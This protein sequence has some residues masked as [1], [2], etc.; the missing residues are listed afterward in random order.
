MNKVCEKK[1]NDNDFIVLC[2]EYKRDGNASYISK[3]EG[4]PLQTLYYYIRKLGYGKSNNRKHNLN[5]DYFSN[6]NSQN[7]AYILGFIM[8]DGCVSKT[9]KKYKNPNRLIL[10]ISK[11]DKCILEFIKKELNCS[12]EIK[13]IVPKDTFSTNEISILTINSIKLCNDL[14]KHG[15][16]ENKTGYEQIPCIQENL[17]RHF[18]RGFLDGDGWITREGRTIGFVSN[19]KML[20]Q[21]KTYLSNHFLLKG[22]LNII[23]DQSKNIF[24]LKI[25]HKEDIINLKRLLYK[26]ANFYLERK[27]NKII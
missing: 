16:I 6:I 7:K 20:E 8:A 5:E 15:I 21:I 25:H 24:Y 12:Y 1:Y 13:D 3:R 10:R 11:K 4:I 18:L 2:E 19:K 17:K 9:S 22:K 14:C 23:E 26:N 27:H